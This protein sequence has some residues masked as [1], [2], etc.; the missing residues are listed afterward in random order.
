[1]AI[2]FPA[3]ST[4]PSRFLVCAWMDEQMLTRVWLWEGA[5]WRSSTRVSSCPQ[6]YIH[7]PCIYTHATSPDNSG[8]TG[9]AEALKGKQ[10]GHASQ[11]SM[12]GGGCKH[13]MSSWPG[14]AESSGRGTYT[15]GCPGSPT[16]GLQILGLFSFHNHISQFLIINLFISIYIYII[17]IS[18]SISYL[19]ICSP[20]FI[21]MHLYLSISMSYWF[22]FSGKPWLI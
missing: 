10:E 4:V 7:T 22:Y 2:T 3:P 15:I 14:R 1:M 21:S 13:S 8:S 6:T 18:I 12:S 16:C 17:Y 9:Q 5:G 19:Y 20:I 11:G